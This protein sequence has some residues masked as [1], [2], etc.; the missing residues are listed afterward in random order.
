MYSI[1]HAISAA[2]AAHS[3]V[4]R[5]LKSGTR[6]SD[7]QEAQEA[8]RAK[9]K[10]MSILD[11]SIGAV[12]S[13]LL[14][15]SSRIAKRQC[16]ATAVQPV[17]EQKTILTRPVIRTIKKGDPP[18]A[19]NSKINNIID[20]MSA[21][22]GSDDKPTMANTVPTL[23]AMAESIG[24]IVT[25]FN[26]V[27]E[28]PYLDQFNATLNTVPVVGIKDQTIMYVGTKPNP[29]PLAPPVE[30]WAVFGSLPSGVT[31]TA[32]DNIHFFP[33]NADFY[34]SIG[35]KVWMKKHREGARPGSDPDPL[36]KKAVDNWPYLYEDTWQY[37]GD[38]ALPAADVK[39][40]VPFATLSADRQAIGFHLAVLLKDQTL[41]FLDADVLQ[42]SN[43]A[44][45]DLKFVPNEAAGKE[46]AWT[47][48]AYWNNYLVALDDSQNFW[49]LK[50]DWNAR[51]YTV[52]DQ[53]KVLQ[54]I[55]E[56]TATEQ[57]LIGVRADGNMWKR[58]LD[59]PNDGKDDGSYAWKAWI[60]QDGVTHLG[61]ASPG[62]LL[63]LHLLTK[64][65][66]SRYLETQSTVAPLMNKMREYG[67]THKFFLQQLRKASDDYVNA[68][69]DAQQTLALKNGK[70]F[71]EHAKTWAKALG[72]ASDHAKEPVNIMTGQLK[73]V[74]AQLVIQLSILKDKLTALKTSLKAQQEYLSQLQAAFWGSIAALLLSIVVAVVG[75]ATMQPWMIAGAGALFVA[76]LTCAIVF[77]K[78]MSD[79]AED[80]ANTQSQIDTTQKAIDELT[81]VASDFQSLSSLYRILNTFFGRMSL[82]AGALADMDDATAIQIGDQVLADPSSIDAAI[83][84]T[85][86]MVTGSGAYLDVLS[87]QGINLPGND[88][89]ESLKYDSVS[90][91]KTFGVKAHVFNIQFHD[92]TAKANEA[93]AQGDT[94]RY[95]KI[96][97]LAATLNTQ[98]VNAD[99]LSVI[100]SG[101][102]FDVPTLNNSGSI[103]A[104]FRKGLGIQGAFAVNLA[105]EFISRSTTLD[106]HFD[107]VRPKVAQLVQQTITLA[108]SVKAW[109]AKYPELPD[110]P[111]NVKDAEIYQNNAVNAC[112][113]AQGS[114]ADANNAFNAFNSE[115]QDFYRTCELQINS[116]NDKAKSAKAGADAEKSSL[117]PPW[118]IIITGAIGVTAWYVSE[119]HKIDDN[120]SNTLNDLNANIDKFKQLEQSG[121]SFDGNTLTWQKMV[122][123]VS[124]DLFSVYSVLTGVEGQLMED[125]NLYKQ[126]MSIEWDELVK[127]SRD[128]LTILGVQSPA[129]SLAALSLTKIPALRSLQF[130]SIGATAATNDNAKLV[131]SLSSNNSLGQ[132]LT[133]QAEQC[134]DAFQQLNLLLEMPYMSD[135]VG[136]WNDSKTEKATLLEVTQK[137]KREYVDVIVMQYD[138][139]QQLYSLSILQ[140][141]RAK[142]ASQGKLPM[143]VFVQNT[144]SSLRAAMEASQSANKAFQANNT[145]F[146]KVVSLIQSNIDDIEKRIAALDTQIESANKQ[147]RD[148]IIGEIADVVALAFATGALLISFGV[149]GPAT[150]AVMGLGAKL[151]ASAAVI[152]ASTKLV[153]DSL[154][155]N[156]LVKFI[157]GLKTS[158]DNLQQSVDRLEAVQPFFKDVVQGI[159]SITETVE[160]MTKTVQDVYDDLS[161]WKEIALTNDDV[162]SIQQS[163]TDLREDCT[164]WMDM[165]HGQNINPVT[166]SRM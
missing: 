163:W 62:V 83:Y 48:M 112:Q 5:A 133:S 127:N 144:L 161:M 101:Q 134:K 43:N 143:N 32:D 93:L 59:P 34:M 129:N 16:N 65:L 91:T 78:K 84:M 147:L 130:A 51:S 30:A 105:Q 156:D 42:G 141:Y 88:A 132:K 99:R 152:A 120:L 46:P 160:D 76:G 13:T 153:L 104:G 149:V 29:K 100:A 26:S 63:D 108:E 116:S 47:S 11:D 15:L 135:I 89:I 37:I 38:T 79:A 72:V 52:G 166:G 118:Y 164:V 140:E 67:V 7:E 55:A 159:G 115:A 158:K 154:S 117:S 53:T 98:S 75:V 8:Q 2:D 81:L 35:Q 110:D 3:T 66:L 69:T 4:S 23:K 39:S 150:A 151:A 119:R 33:Y 58:V 92:T 57:G 103:W 107:D 106:G 148:K 94:D 157:A 44:W 111:A 6:V 87:A 49:N 61:V 73:D 25:N 113:K 109:A 138:S 121:A 36:L 137:L 126:L 1:S 97:D 28:K 24:P 56:L 96:M 31:V 146:Q 77:G 139:V 95:L 40:V 20:T 22:K 17:V 60:K 21:K 142:N 85:D 155:I 123:T 82:D 45:T 114:A 70:T 64:T 131:A 10:T 145:E 54:P 122:Q 41:Q 71:V 128:T 19:S 162:K 165:V 14:R 27:L 68:D 9:V 18:A 102:W 124:Q 12:G 90:P 136:F 86:E 125:P 50:P 74:E 80:V